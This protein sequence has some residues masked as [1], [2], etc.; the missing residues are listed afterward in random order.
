MIDGSIRVGGKNMGR[1]IAMI[2][3]PYDEKSSF[4]KG[5][6]EAPSKIREALN[7]PSSNLWTERGVDLGKDDVL[8][9]LGDVDWTGSGDPLARIEAAISALLK[10]DVHPMVLGGDHAITYPVIRAV[11]KRFQSLTILHFDAHPDLYEEFHGDRYSHAC[12]FSRIME[13][14]LIARLIQVGVRTLNEHQ[15]IQAE[16]FGVEWIEMKDLDRW[17]RLDF[18]S[19]LY[20]SFDLDALDPAFAPGVSH[21]EPG[22]LSTRQVIDMIHSLRATVIGAD[23]VEL[24]PRR[25]PS[26]ITAMAAAK[27]LKEIAGICLSG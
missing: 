26:G 15:R 23:I 13:Q 5:S 25:D 3:V 19:P 22:G 12:P 1:K 24:N 8:S 4:L 9:D 10:T 21:P 16:K 18:V 2:G 14:G 27:I 7:S 17:D 6:A 11:A 20:I